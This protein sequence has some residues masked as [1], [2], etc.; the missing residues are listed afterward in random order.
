M[1][2]SWMHMPNT[3]KYIQGVDIFLDFAYAQARLGV[4]SIELRMI[5]HIIQMQ[6]G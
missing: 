1:D 4:H 3:P 2:K 6:V 5:S